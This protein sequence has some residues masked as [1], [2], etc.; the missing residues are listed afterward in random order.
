M[1]RKY[2]ANNE[3]RAEEAL[4]TAVETSETSETSQV[5]DESVDSV[6]IQES[7]EA[8][9]ATLESTAENAGSL[10]EAISAGAEAASS[11]AAGLIPAVGGLIHKGV[12]NGFYCLSYGV[13]FG[14]LVV[15][16]LI[17]SNN[18][19]GDGVRN[20]FKAAHKDFEAKHAAIQAEAP[21]DEGLVPA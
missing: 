17:P 9:Q 19:M 8:S 18:A 5:L 1:A 10:V 15:G 16:K 13:V 7:T 2:A 6:S 11:A 20:G 4:E 12:Y 21:A 14:A 3:E